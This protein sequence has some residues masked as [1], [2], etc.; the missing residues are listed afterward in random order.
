MERPQA[1]ICRSSG[2]YSFDAHGR[3]NHEC[4]CGLVVH[5]PRK[6]HLCEECD[7]VWSGDVRGRVVAT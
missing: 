5:N 1:L 7:A 3:I 2:G 4:R 6:G